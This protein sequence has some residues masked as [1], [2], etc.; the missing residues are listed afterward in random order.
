MIVFSAILLQEK[1][2]NSEPEE[3]RQ[4]T[5]EQCYNSIDLQNSP[6]S[7]HKDLKQQLKLFWSFLKLEQIYK[8][9]IF[10]FMYMITPSYGD[11]LFYFYTNELKFSPLTM[12]RLRLVYGVATIVGIWIYNK[13]LKNVSF[14][15]IIWATTILSMVFNL[16]SIVLVTRLN[17]VLGIPDFWFCLTADA[18]TTALAEINTMPLLVLACNICPK[19]IEG[20]LYAFLMSVLNLGNLI[21]SQ[22][23]A[24]LTTSLGITNSNFHNLSWLIF[25]ANIVLVLPMPLLYLIKEDS[26]NPIKDDEAEDVESNHK[27][28]ESITTRL[29]S[30]KKGLEHYEVI[31][32]QNKNEKASIHEKI[33]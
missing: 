13:Y 4:I 16:F 29:S 30:Q 25:I 23:G 22:L 32:S 31:S 28:T 18:L 7:E 11:P 5:N 33:V 15:L 14:K 9:V 3:T 20:T 6:H 2:V 8:P 27:D 19:D 17:L 24:V 21:S 26:Y 10:I 1:K 12:G